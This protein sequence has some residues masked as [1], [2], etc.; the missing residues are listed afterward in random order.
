MDRRGFLKLGAQLAG[1][2]AV[3]GATVAAQGAFAMEADRAAKFTSVL[4]GAPANSGID[5][6]VIVMMENRSFD[7]YLGWLNRDAKY[8]ADGK[9]RFGSGFGVLGNIHQTFTAPDGKR[10][11]TEPH[12]VNA[13]PINS[14][15]GCG[16]PDPGHGWR[17][18]RAERDFGFLA[19][20]SGND[21]FALSYFQ[22][23]DLPIYAALSRRFTICDRWHAAL[24]GPTYPNRE[25]LLSGQSGGHKDNYLPLAE[26]GFQWPAIFDRLNA[27]GVSV[28]DYASDFPPFILFGDRTAPY[29]RTLDD[30]HADA[31]AGT[32]AQVSY[33]DPSFI[34]DGENDDHP[35]ADP[36]AGQLFIRDV[37]RSFTRSPQWKRGL[38]LVMYDEWGGFF[39]HI[40]PPVAL[41]DRS[42]P[43]DDENFGQC[44]FRV[45]AIIASPRALHGYVDH[46]QYDHTSVLRF[47]EWRFLGAP[48]NGPLGNPANPWWLTTRDRHARN[49]G[50]TLSS[51][52]FD[53]N[54]H[55]DIDMHLAAPSPPCGQ[56]AARV[57]GSHPFA[58]AVEQGYLE[59]LGAG[60]RLRHIA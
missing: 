41:D 19:S 26:G 60:R 16:H 37:V 42:S 13:G 6:V 1:A 39:D 57:L 59:R 8:I 9:S 34:G 28:A 48:A 50:R 15:E 2:G 30:F 4:A 24:L 17:A 14:W 49:L 3:G 23:T 36:R 56:D 25:Y 7:S 11:K 31:A 29:L 47:L 54:L 22:R 43:I 20:D 27:A 58:T 53:P 51:T 10:V 12:G 21:P 46:T 32:L 45:P 44:G 52:V 33:V 40:A 55:F 38:L 35:L 5:T 18:G